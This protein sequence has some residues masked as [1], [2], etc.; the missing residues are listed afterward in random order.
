MKLS[1]FTV[2]SGPKLLV[3]DR[4]ED[5]LKSHANLSYTPDAL[6]FAARELSTG[7]RDRRFGFSAS[8]LGSCPRAQQLTFLGVE[9]NTLRP[10]QHQVA[11]NGNFMHLRWQMAGISAGWLAEPEV[12]IPENKF[13]LSGTMDGVLDTGQGLELKSCN[14]HAFSGVNSFGPKTEH[15]FQVHTYMLATNINVFSLIYENKD[16]QFWKEFVVE[17][18]EGLIAKVKELALMLN[19]RTN[20]HE[21]FPILDKCEVEEGWQYEWCDKRVACKAMETWPSSQEN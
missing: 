17:R 16:T 15:L 4:H 18:N 13:G 5:W 14:A 12:P 11:H 7:D 8:S 19:A 3:T 10:R 21:L 1:T 2:E 6:A 9:R 20:A